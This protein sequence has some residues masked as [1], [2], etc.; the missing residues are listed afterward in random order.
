MLV[1][2]CMTGTVQTVQADDD[3][4]VVRELFRRR[5]IRHVPVVAAGRVVG[6]VSDRDVRGLAAD[7]SPT[8][9][10]AI[11]TP[12]PATTTPSTPVETAAAVMRARKIGALP[13]LEGHEL[14]GIV[15]ESDLLGA[16]VELCNVVDPTSVLE[17]D[18]EDDPAAPRRIRQLVE[19]HGGAVAWMTAIRSHG[20]RQQVTLRLRMPQAHTPSQMFEE[21]GFVVKSC[22]T[23]RVTATTTP[24][25]PR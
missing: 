22:L 12:A 5:R 17:L 24:Q 9:V 14:V 20:G 6:I 11:M 1:R 8:S 3:V 10:D 7:R 19:R 13:V 25:H 4:A 15:S 16:L 21:A 23:G 18:C 2:N